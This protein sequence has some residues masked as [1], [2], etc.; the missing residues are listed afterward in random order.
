MTLQD[1]IDAETK[2]GT[3]KPGEVHLEDVNT[4]RGLMY[5]EWC[6]V[7][8]VGHSREYAAVAMIAKFSPLVIHVL[9]DIR[10]ICKTAELCRQDL[11]FSRWLEDESYSSP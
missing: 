5:H 6:F 1:V 11:E 7:R 8:R 9:G 4:R 3:L 10:L 2:R